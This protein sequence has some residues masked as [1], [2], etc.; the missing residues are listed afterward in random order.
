MEKAAHKQ[1]EL[2]EDSQ[3]AMVGEPAVL[4]A[5]SP[6]QESIVLS[7]PYGVDAD[8]L[9]RKVNAYYD[10][11]LQEIVVERN[12][13]ELVMQWLNRA[14]LYSGPGLCWDNEPFRRLQEMSEQVLLMFDR[15][16]E[17]AP[18]YAHRHLGWLKEKLENG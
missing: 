11:I 2:S 6:A 16:I 12:V 13:K 18:D 3:S 5:S 10:E 14:G 17:G 1:Y 9:R 15:I 7:I 4:Y 8:S